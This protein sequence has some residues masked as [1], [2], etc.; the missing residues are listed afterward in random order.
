MSGM[1]LLQLRK[2]MAISNLNFVQLEEVFERN[3][4]VLVSAGFGILCFLCLLQQF[5]V[6]L[7]KTW[8]S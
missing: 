6:R 7:E 1:R 2:I 8:L 5:L 4:T 3:V